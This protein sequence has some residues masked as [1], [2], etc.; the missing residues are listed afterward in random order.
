[1]HAEDILSE[2]KCKN[3]FLK[4][5]YKSHGYYNWEQKEHTDFSDQKGKEGKCEFWKRTKILNTCRHSTIQIIQKSNFDHRLTVT[6]DKNHKKSWQ[7]CWQYCKFGGFSINCG[8][9]IHWD[10]N[11]IYLS[12]SLTWKIFMAW[13]WLQNKFH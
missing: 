8:K 1:M 6:K 9:F 11:A 10:I 4:V 2:T 5:I 3:Y 13:C 7:Q 12:T